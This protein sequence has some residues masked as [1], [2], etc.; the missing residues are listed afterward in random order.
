MAVVDQWL[1]LKQM[2]KCTSGCTWENSEA[3]GEYLLNYSLSTVVYL[4]GVVWHC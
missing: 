1:S 3:V 4:C 2:L